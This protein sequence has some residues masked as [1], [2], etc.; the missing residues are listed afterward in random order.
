MNTATMSKTLIASAIALTF[1]M[2]ALADDQID[3]L[4][5]QIEALQREVQTLKATVQNQNQSR[6]DVKKLEEK[7]AKVEGRQREWNWIPS[8]TWQAMGRLAIQ[9]TRMPKVVSARCSS[10]PF[11]T[12]CTKIS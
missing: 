10:R 7:V 1:P 9:T 3:A 6:E 8:C 5:R 4:K 11:S 2:A 12:T